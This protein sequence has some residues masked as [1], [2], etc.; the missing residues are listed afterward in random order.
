MKIKQK[1]SKKDYEHLLN[2]TIETLEDEIKEAKK[3]PRPVTYGIALGHWQ[4]LDSLN[5]AMWLDG[6]ETN[7]NLSKMVDNY[8]KEI[9]EIEII[10]KGKNKN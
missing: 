3:D 7:K 2:R 4:V 6:I 5:N 8:L 10:I 9:N 1:P